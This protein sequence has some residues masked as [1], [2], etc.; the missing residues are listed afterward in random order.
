MNYLIKLDGTSSPLMQPE[1]ILVQSG[2]NWKISEVSKPE[3]EEEN[4]NQ[5]Q[6]FDLQKKP[7]IHNKCLQTCKLI[8]YFIFFIL[9]FNF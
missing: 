5:I 7:L 2:Y 9:S 1:E 4:L 8:D 3:D 6:Y